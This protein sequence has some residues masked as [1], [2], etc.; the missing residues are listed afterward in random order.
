MATT[1]RA[2]LVRGNHLNELITEREHRVVDAKFRNS[3]V[4]EWLAQTQNLCQQ[5]AGSLQITGGK[6]DLA[7][8]HGGLTVDYGG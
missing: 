4:G 7:D 2:R 5:I 8:A 3:R 1:S 6:N